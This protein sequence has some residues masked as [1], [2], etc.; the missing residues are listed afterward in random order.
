MALLSIM[1]TC[2]AST[3]NWC[4]L[5]TLVGCWGGKTRCLLILPLERTNLLLTDCSDDSA[6]GAE[7]TAFGIADAEVG[8][9]SA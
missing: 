5:T 2:S 1:E 4:C 7:D 3:L 9:G 6:A 8:T